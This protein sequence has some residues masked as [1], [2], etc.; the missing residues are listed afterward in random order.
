VPA[1][2]A[3]SGP[4]V[5][6]APQK[7]PAQSLVVYD[8]GAAG[9]SGE[10]ARY[11]IPQ[12]NALEATPADGVASAPAFDA[13]GLPVFL[14]ES[15]NGGFGLFEQPKGS[16]TVDALQLFFGVP[17]T[18]TSLAVDA[19][20]DF[21]VAQ[22]CSG[23]VLEYSPSKSK[24]AKKP[25][26]VYSG[27][28][29]GGMGQPNPTVAAVDPSGNLYVGDYSG[30]ITFFAAGSTKGVVALPTGMSQLVTQIFIDAKGDAWSTHLANPTSYY[31]KNEKTWANTSRTGSWSRNS[32]AR[33]PLRNTMPRKANRSRSIR[34]AS[35]IS[36]RTATAS[37]S[38]SR[39]TR[40][41]PARI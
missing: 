13:A 34:P 6:L 18:S 8:I 15:N 4:L 21:Y 2:A 30:G 24:K 33:R 19:K 29:F 11:G 38:C 41:N 1:L 20:G 25:I 36:V 28:N 14:D 7:K 10:F 35:P 9:D 37:R 40:A 27:G 5:Q 31:F 12:L 23:Q 32:T 26:A 3:R 17:C 22:Y 39:T 16:G